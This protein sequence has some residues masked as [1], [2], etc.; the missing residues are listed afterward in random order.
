MRDPQK[1][2]YVVREKRIFVTS[3]KVNF[4]SDEE[5]EL[6]FAAGTK[7]SERSI[8]QLV[9]EVMTRVAERTEYRE[10][11]FLRAQTQTHQR[12]V[13]V[14]QFT[15][16]SMVYR[17][18]VRFFQIPQQN[19]QQIYLAPR[20]NCTNVRGLD[21][22]TIKMATSG[23]REPTTARSNGRYVSDESIHYRRTVK[24]ASRDG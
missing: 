14:R 3:F 20:T 17:E 13:N 7:L 18:C 22:R 1:N 16:L 11:V 9:D 12:D 10:F 8:R 5:N 6:T 23:A 4:D 24:F 21:L 15:H 19:T 2:T